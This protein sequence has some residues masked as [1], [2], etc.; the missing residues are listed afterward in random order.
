MV[1]AKLRF[2]VRYCCLWCYGDQ[3]ENSDRVSSYTKAYEI[4]TYGKLET[5]GMECKRP[6]HVGGE[7]MLRDK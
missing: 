1:D 3:L 2:K 5:R 4:S 6:R 7:N